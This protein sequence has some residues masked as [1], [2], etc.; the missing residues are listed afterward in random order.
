MKKKDY[1][2][3]VIAILAIAAIATYT[4]Y[5]AKKPKGNYAWIKT[6]DDGMVHPYDLGVMKAILKNKAGYN[7]ELVEEKLTDKI[8]KYQP[9]DTCTYVFIGRYCYLRRDEID[10]LLDFAEMGHEVVLIAEGLP[11]TLL[12][13]LSYYAK[14]VTIQR[15]DEP[16]VDIETYREQ[17][18]VKNHQF[19]FRSFDQATIETDWYFLDEEQQLDYYFGQTG[20]RYIRAGKINGKLNYAKFKVGNGFIYIHTSPLLFTNYALKNDSGYHYVDEVFS[21]MQMGGHIVY[22]VYSRNYKEDAERIQ[23]KSDSPLSY[24]LKQP[25]LKWAWYLFL[26]AVL[27]FFLFKAKRKQRLIPVLE[28]KRNTSVRFIETLSGL[29]YHDA[30]HQQMAETRMSLFLFFLRSKLNISTHEI[31][32]DT[33]RLVSVKSKVPESDIQRIFDYYYQV[34][35]KDRESVRSENLM[36][37]YNRIDTFYQLYN[38]KK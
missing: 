7:F 10:A 2:V 20:N 36:E 12:Q 14:P 34:I 13:T 15:F 22:D 18:K 38:K 9:I 19:K 26:G 30:N 31:N 16:V 23:R 37:F 11:D 4:A 6:Y 29:F 27:M 33:I 21:G 28:Q 3:L 5:S 8:G 32:P 17:S 35:Q 1:T 25:A 24:I